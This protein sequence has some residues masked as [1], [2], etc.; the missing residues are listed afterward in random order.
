MYD[1]LL[2]KNSLMDTHMVL[3]DMIIEL[4]SED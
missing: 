2:M 4:E 3:A 1:L